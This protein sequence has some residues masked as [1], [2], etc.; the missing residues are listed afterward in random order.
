M[1][2]ASYADF[3]MLDDDGDPAA[4]IRHARGVHAGLPPVWLLHLPVGD[5]A[6]SLRRVEDGGG[7]VLKQIAADEVQAAYAAIEDPI[8]ARVALVAG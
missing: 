8:G 4:A 7:K 6:E 1:K 5:L 3:A 2:G